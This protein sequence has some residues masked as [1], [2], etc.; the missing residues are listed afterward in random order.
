[1]R[2]SL[3]APEQLD[4]ARNAA[5][6]V[7]TYLRGLIHSEAPR[8]ARAA[9]RVTIKR[10]PLRKRAAKPPSRPGKRAASS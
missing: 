3:E 1:M 8:A 6:L 5:V 10:S 4:L 9:R 2:D 7:D